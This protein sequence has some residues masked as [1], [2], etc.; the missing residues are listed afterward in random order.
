MTAMRLPE[1]VVSLRSWT[2][3]FSMGFPLFAIAMAIGIAESQSQS[4]LHLQDSMAGDWPLE[5]AANESDLFRN[6]AGTVADSPSPNRR[7]ESGNPID[8]LTALSL[9]G[10]ND[11]E[12]RIMRETLREA[13]AEE[14]L[15]NVQFL[16]DVFVFGDF[17]KH[18]GRIQ[19]TIGDLPRASKQSLYTGIG[20]SWVYDFNQQRYERLA[21]QQV[22]GAREQ[23]LRATRESRLHRAANLYFRLLG[24][25]ARAEVAEEATRR[26]KALVDYQQNLL[27]RG[28]GLEADLRRAEAFHAGLKQR[29]VRAK[30]ELEKT[31]IELAT[32]LKI[33]PEHTVGKMLTGHQAQSDPSNQQ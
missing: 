18:E 7:E 15:A 23:E 17:Y 10:A 4:G 6:R 31:S 13:M 19:G 1:L 11:L 29:S 21:K 24:A 28:K 22:R 33:D 26:G 9:A 32:I 14:R 5:V 8:L 16:P 12:I 27:N 25:E 30:A 20:L 2:G 3:R